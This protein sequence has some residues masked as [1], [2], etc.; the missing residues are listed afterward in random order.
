MAWRVATVLGERREMVKRVLDGEEGVTAVSRE[1][2]VSRQTAEPGREPE[3]EP[4][5]SLEQPGFLGNFGGL[6]GRRI[7]RQLPSGTPR[8]VAINGIRADHVNVVNVPR[9]LPPGFSHASQRHA[10]KLV[11]GHQAR[12]KAATTL[13]TGCGAPDF[14]MDA[15][16]ETLWTAA[17]GG[18]NSS[19]CREVANTQSFPKK[20]CIL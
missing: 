1:M 12:M 9:F 19:P 16:L 5:N 7:R 2:G 3:R 17:N 18:S 13:G 15:K 20:E 6:I 10:G 4:L 8:I 14:G 11:M